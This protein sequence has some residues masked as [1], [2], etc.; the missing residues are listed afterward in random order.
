MEKVKL[1]MSRCEYFAFCK[2]TVLMICKCFLRLPY[3]L[4]VMVSSIMKWLW[5]KIVWF[6]KEYTKAA[7]VMGYAICFAIMLTE[8][9]LLKVEIRKESDK[10]GELIEENYL[11][12]QADRYDKGYADGIRHIQPNK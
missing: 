4:A 12:R 9:V 3:G 6:C 2:S 8:F 11:L 10:I 5:D 7:V 1:I